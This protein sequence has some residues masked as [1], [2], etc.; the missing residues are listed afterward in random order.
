MLTKLVDEDEFN[1]FTDRTAENIKQ[2]KEN[3]DYLDKIIAEGRVYGFYS[4]DI[5][6]TE[7]E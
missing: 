5:D 7:R 2:S 6:Q 1:E 3:C 4:R